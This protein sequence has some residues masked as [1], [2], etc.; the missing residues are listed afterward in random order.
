M[1]SP[2]LKICGLQTPAEA[3]AARAAG[4]TALGL[5]CG[6]THRAED[7]V[8]PDQA[9][10]I[11]ASL[12]AAAPPCAVLVTHLATA[13]AIAG[14]AARLDEAAP[15]PGA[16]LAA[17]QVHG[18]LPPEELRRLGPLLRPGLRRIKAVHVT[19]DAAETIARALAFAPDA[20]ALLLDTRTA[21]R[22]GGTGRTHDWSVSRQVVRAVAPLPVFLAGG[23]TPENVAEAIRTVRPA[24]VDV[25][26]GVEAPGGA[27]DPERMRRFV[28][29]AR[30][31]LAGA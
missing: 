21:D 10:R 16:V 22:L 17:V 3:Q 27:K 5:L 6:L 19:G 24:G 28:A 23:L 4:A 15:H 1:G 9:R 14:L 11:L 12:P 26:S 29:A 8:T 2:F 25:N 31:A 30:D 20:D 18:D 7:Q 13:K